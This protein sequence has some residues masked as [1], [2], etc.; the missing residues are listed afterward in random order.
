MAL[1]VLP[2]STHSNLQALIPFE[3]IRDIEEIKQGFSCKKYVITTKLNN[4][5]LLRI[6]KLQSDFELKITQIASK[7]KISPKLVACDP[8]HQLILL[9]YIFCQKWPSFEADPTPYCEAMRLLRIFHNYSSQ[10]VNRENTDIF[11][12]YS[13]LIES[14]KK[15]KQEIPYLPLHFSKAIKKIKLIFKSLTP[16][17]K[18]NA[19]YCHGD[20]HKENALYDGKKVFLID[21]ETAALGDPVLD[22]AKFTLNLNLENRM[23]LY[24]VYLEHDPLPEEIAHFQLI[25]LTFLI[26]VTVNRM[27]L[28]HKHSSQERLSKQDMEQLLSSDSQLPSFLSVSYADA[29]PIA[30][31]KGAIYALGEFLSKTQED[32]LSQLLAKI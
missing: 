27:C 1:S 32:A 10:I 3:E 28:A 21:W 15:M 31:Q 19:A 23:K 18:K 13:H 29:T 16:W 17:L 30:R 11:S 2:S 25:D 22:I 8:E 20:F 4:K 5:Y 6:Q 14:G 9:E 7:L 24:A 26:V 12:P